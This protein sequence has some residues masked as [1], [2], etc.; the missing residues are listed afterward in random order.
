MQKIYAAFCKNYFQSPLGYQKVFLSRN[1]TKRINDFCWTV[2]RLRWDLSGFHE[3]DIATLHDAFCVGVAGELAV[4]K[5]LGG[6][7]DDVELDVETAVTNFSHADLL[8][9]GY[10]IGIKTSRF[11]NP[12]LLKQEPTNPEIIC[13]VCRGDIQ[14]DPSGAIEHI[15]GVVVNGIATEEVQRQYQ[16]RTLVHHPE[17]HTLDDRGGFYGYPY[18]LPFTGKESLTPYK[19]KKERE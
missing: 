1:D 13:T 16:S 5:L 3:K 18:L 7:I 12:A 15:A 19:I 17:H 2:A 4:V 6:S 9:F 10:N 8:H 14:T 11:G